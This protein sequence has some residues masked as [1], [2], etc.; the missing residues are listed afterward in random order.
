[1]SLLKYKLLIFFQF[2]FAHVR[3]PESKIELWSPISLTFMLVSESYFVIKNKIIFY[4]IKLIHYVVF[5]T[6]S[7]L[8]F[9]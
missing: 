3:W 6:S 8:I 9:K 2:T 1:M 7:V 5:C 4:K